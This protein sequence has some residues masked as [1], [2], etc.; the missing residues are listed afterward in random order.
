M[1]PIVLID[2]GKVCTSCNQWKSID[3]FY[4]TNRNRLHKHLSVCK[5]CCSVKAVKQREKHRGTCKIC[6]ISVLKQSTY[7]IKCVKKTEAF[8]SKS[9]ATYKLHRRKNF[10]VDCGIQVDLR[11]SRCVR[12]NRT[13]EHNAQWKGGVTILKERLRDL[14]EYR[15]WRSD[16]FTR[17][18]FTCLE[19]GQ[20][21]EGLNAHHIIP[22]NVLIQKNEL[23]NIEMAKQCDELWNINNGSTYCK[24]CHGDIHKKEGYK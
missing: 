12:C 22:L 4:L 23:T 16:V 1:Q 5:E 2:N 24:K 11:S 10:C 21:G 8:Q 20:V 18:H 14:F 17:D 13:G 15:Q 7:C 6:G 3:S 9:R 19:C